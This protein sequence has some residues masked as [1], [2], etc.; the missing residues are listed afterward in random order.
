M[1]VLRF[2]GSREDW[3]EQEQGALDRLREAFAEGRFEVECSHTEEG[4]PWCIVHD[5]QHDRIV[6][7]IARIR[8]QYVLVRPDTGSI[9][10]TTTIETIIDVALGPEGHVSMI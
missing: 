4:E 1:T 10:R 8:G 5:R 9:K 6:L 3:T 7:H 2:T